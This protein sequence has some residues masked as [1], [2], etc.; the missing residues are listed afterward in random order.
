MKHVYRKLRPSGRQRLEQLVLPGLE[1]YGTPDM[2]IAHIRKSAVRYRQFRRMD[3]RQSK[4]ALVRDI[5]NAWL[6]HFM[7]KMGLT[8]DAAYSILRNNPK[9]LLDWPP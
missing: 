7:G 2:R 3:P 9:V 8:A 4:R 5:M 1:D 6:I